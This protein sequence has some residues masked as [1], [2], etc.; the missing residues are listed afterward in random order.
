MELA[1]A[2]IRAFASSKSKAEVDIVR[3]ARL[4]KIAGPSLNAPAASWRDFADYFKRWRNLRMLLGTTLS[5]FF[6]VSLGHQTEH[7]SRPT[8]HTHTH[9]HKRTG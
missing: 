1:D 5:W 2:N 9:K 6:L 3:Q 4:K 8:S 7:P